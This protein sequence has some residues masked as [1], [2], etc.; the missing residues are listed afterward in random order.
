MNKKIPNLTQPNKKLSLSNLVKT[1]L[2]HRY[3]IMQSM[4]R[5]RKQSLNTKVVVVFASLINYYVMQTGPSFHTQSSYYVGTVW[6]TEQECFL[7]LQTQTAKQVWLY[8]VCLSIQSPTLVV[9]LFAYYVELSL[10][11]ILSVHFVYLSIIFPSFL[12][13]Y[14]LIGHIYLSTYCFSMLFSSQSFSQLNVCLPIFD[15]LL[16]CFIT[17]IPISSTIKSYLSY[18]AS[19]L[20]YQ[21]SVL[22]F[23]N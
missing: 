7:F 11:Y 14:Q 9:H 2:L 17:S 13:L 12:S 5:I 16:V 23:S 6:R 3:L 19:K 10:A 4:P 22:F 15:D 21:F 20:H 8:F 18:Q 1:N